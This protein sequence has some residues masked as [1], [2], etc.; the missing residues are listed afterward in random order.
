MSRGPK[1]SIPKSRGEASSSHQDNPP[2]GPS[3][4]NPTFSSEA[5]MQNMYAMRKEQ[6]VQ[7]KILRK[8][9]QQYKWLQKEVVHFFQ[10]T[11]HCFTPPP[12]MH[13]PPQQSRAEF[14]QG[15]HHSTNDESDDDAEGGRSPEE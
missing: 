9:A 10:K 1:I 15:F 7:S 14:F 5:I 13:L 8:L 12:E 3:S 4:S 6:R 11:A 2:S